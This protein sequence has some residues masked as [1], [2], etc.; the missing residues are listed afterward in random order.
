[1]KHVSTLGAVT[2]LLLSS[3]LLSSCSLFAGGDDPGDDTVTLVVHGSF[4]LPT[5]LVEQFEQESGLTLRITE[6]GDGGSLTNALALNVNNPTGDV[7]F[8]VDNTFASRAIDEGVFA[9]YVVDLPSGADELRL[10]G[11]GAN[12]M[13]PIDQASVCVNVDLAWFAAREM[14][15]PESL[16]DLADPTYRD[17]FVAPGATTS[18]PGMAFLLAT[19]AEYGDEWPAYWEKLVANGVELAEGWEDAYYG[20]FTAAAE[21]GERPIVVSYDTSP[22]FTIDDAG[23]TTTRA[24]LDTCFRQVEYAGV[25][26]NAKNPE[27]AQRVIDFLLSDEVQAAL[28]TSMYVFPVNDEV[29]LPED[30]AAFAEKPTDPKD[31]D[32]AEIAANRA[33]WLTRWTEIISR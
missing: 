23:N 25:L 8:G 19:I 16:A 33:D 10:D 12:R 28:P 17:L 6:G 31:V 30:W 27:G 5:E 26:R 14:P 32:P 15:P 13:I 4:D 3:A 9:E 29:A 22:A 24:L 1:M 20:S 18:T 11:E 2:A 21:Q 7:A